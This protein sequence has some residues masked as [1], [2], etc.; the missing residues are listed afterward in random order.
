M[1]PHNMTLFA[2]F[3][4]CLQRYVVVF[5][6]IAFMAVLTAC[7]DD[8][9]NAQ[10]VDDSHII[11]AEFS[12]ETYHKNHTISAF[13][14]AVEQAQLAFQVSGRLAEQ[15]VEIGQ[16]VNQGEPLLRL[17][18]PGLEPQI[19]AIE[20]QLQAN[21]VDLKQ[22]ESELK[23]NQSLSDIQAIS[24]N[25]LERLQSQVDQLKAQQVRLVAQLQAANNQFKE[26]TLS[27]P[28]KGEVAD[29]LVK[30]GT[31]VQAG[32]PVIELSGSQLFEAPLYIGNDL[33]SHLN[34][35]QTLNANFGT[36]ELT[37][38]IKEIS[39]SANPS[40]QLFKVLVQ[41]PANSQL[42]AGQKIEVVL[43]EPLD[44]IYQL[45]VSAV[46]DDGINEPYV[47]ALDNG[48]VKHYSVQV[49]QF[50]DNHIWVNIRNQ[51]GKLNIIT[52]GQSTVTPPQNKTA[53]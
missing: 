50:Y 12:P 3:F 21:S 52:A 45:P 17:Y 5:L 27:A 39:R 37:V 43:P 34:V 14:Q 25:Q 49:L 30:P 35:N 6:L 42:M 11:S 51:K 15:W 36:Q 46:I 8:S 19:N 47:Y 31:Q 7:Q 22:T 33:L 29:I 23:R 18:N 16:Q 24:Q 2:R 26:A 4:Q 13:V 53:P 48:V 40:S 44:N 41:L 10:S 20:A 9:T 32:Q 1:N 38:T 28:F